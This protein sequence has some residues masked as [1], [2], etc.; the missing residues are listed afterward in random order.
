MDS[1]DL[2]ADAGLDGQS[3]MDPDLEQAGGVR[4]GN[5]MATKEATETVGDAA[6]A[7][8][9]DSDLGLDDGVWAA[10]DVHTAGAATVGVGSTVAAARPSFH[11]ILAEQCAGDEWGVPEQEMEPEVEVHDGEISYVSGKYGLA[12]KLS[13]SFKERLEKRWDYTVVVKL[14][15]RIVGYH[16]LCG[17]LQTLWKPSRPMKVVDLEEDFFLVR[18]NCEEDYYRALTGGPWI[19]LGHAL[20]VQPWDSTFRPSNGRVSQAVI[21]ARFADFPPCWYNTE[22]LRASGNLVGGSMRVDA[23]TKEAIGGKY[24]RVAVEVNL[25]KPLRGIVEFDDMDFK[26]SYEGLPSVCYGCGSMGAQF[27]FMSISEEV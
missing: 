9:M 22:V 27:G 23:N 3:T 15:G 17:R 6:A 5:T 24:A 1:D 2:E 8:A 11:D 12:V 20:S 19:I 4:V 26:V 25:T 14:L 21:W 16:T 7:A 18:L 10:D 13:E